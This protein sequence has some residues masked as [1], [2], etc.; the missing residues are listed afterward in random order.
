MSREEVRRLF[1]VLPAPPNAYRFFAFDRST[2]I[3]ANWDIIGVWVQRRDPLLLDVFLIHVS[4]ARI[5]RLSNL[6]ASEWLPDDTA[7]DPPVNLGIEEPGNIGFTSAEYLVL[8]N[9]FERWTGSVPDRAALGPH[10][11]PV[12]QPAEFWP[13]DP[14]HLFTADPCYRY[15]PDADIPNGANVV[16]VVSPPKWESSA[17]GPLIGYVGF[18]VF[19]REQFLNPDFDPYI[20]YGLGH[21]TLNAGALRDL[22]VLLRHHTLQTE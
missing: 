4:Q 12:T 18:T 7:S 16:A 19:E 22:V 6:Y 5:A 21:I 11:R 8:I 10:F 1:I 20:E 13:P 2:P 14:D 17:D 3:P 9:F 15:Y